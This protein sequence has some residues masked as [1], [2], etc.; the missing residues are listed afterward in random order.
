MDRQVV[1]VLDDPDQVVETLSAFRRQILH[2]L[3]SDPASATQIA[4]NL[5][6]TRQRVNY[7]LKALEGAG[8]VELH[9]ERQRRGLTERVMRTSAE[10]LLVDPS[11]F[12]TGRL[13]RRDVAGVGAVVS[14]ATDLIRQAAVIST[15]AGERDERVA[16]ASLD[17]HIRVKSPWALQSMLDE[18]GAV[19]ARHDSGDS[20][21]RVRVA[22]S[23]LPG[24]DEQ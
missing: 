17:T 10:V 16:A 24:I 19:I 2:V 6:T 18:I 4:R 14:V 3:S 13:T 1:T 20:G 12:D 21:L 9:E 15:R 5:D 23:V 11:A 8:L 22:T 7:H